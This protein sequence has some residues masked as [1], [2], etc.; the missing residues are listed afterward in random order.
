MSEARWITAVVL[1]VTIG[2]PVS[3]AL[4]KVWVAQD[5][6]QAGY[7]LSAREDERRRLR[8]EL[9]QL[10][11]ELASERTPSRLSDLAHTLGL[12][13]P[14]PRAVPTVTSVRERSLRTSQPAPRPRAADAKSGGRR[15]RP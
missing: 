15:G 8:N 6:V 13:P 7:R 2:A 10:E 4:F 3:A 12:E 9:R 5:A 11:V 1:S 14:A